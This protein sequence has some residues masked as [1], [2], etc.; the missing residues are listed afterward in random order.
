MSALDYSLLVQGTD[1]WA[2]ARCGK[3]TASRSKDAF[4]VSESGKTKGC[5]MASRATYRTELICERLTEIPYPQY[6]TRE[7]EW[8]RLQERAAREA[9][10]V[11]QAVFVQKVGFVVHP[12]HPYF[13]CSPDG[14]V[15]DRGMLQIKCPTTKV[16]LEWLTAGTI[17]FEHVWQLLSE[18]ACN[19]E[20][21]WIDFMSFDPRLPEHLQKFIKRYHRDEKLI[22][23]LESEVVHF[24]T[25]V[26][27]AI[28]ALPAGPQPAAKLL[29]MPRPEEAEF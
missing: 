5:Y 12:E 20:R 24:N 17:P 29:E 25:E 15:G 3:I 21:E 26:D 8:G 9:Y 28:L 2:Q 10:E 13:G 27:Q 4:C 7:M 19:P 1:E 14:L 6:V 11:D 18:L 22:I 23:A 16:H